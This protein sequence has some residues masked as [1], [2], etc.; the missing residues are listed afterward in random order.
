M[1]ADGEVLRSVADV[2]ELLEHQLD[3]LGEFSRG[4]R[5]SELDGLDEGILEL[6][7][8]LV[9]CLDLEYVVS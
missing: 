5:C 9:G 2:V 3:L 4:W 1:K 7:I 6:L 8:Q